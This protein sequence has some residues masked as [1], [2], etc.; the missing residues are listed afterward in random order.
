VRLPRD[1]S[2]L[3]RCSALCWGRT[4]SKGNG[5]FGGMIHGFFGMTGAV[6]MAC[7]AI[8]EAGAALEAAFATA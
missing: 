6:D 8:D 7:Q 2:A 3:T 1:V 5:C 4:L